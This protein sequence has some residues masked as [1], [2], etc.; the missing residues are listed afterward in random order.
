VGEGNSFQKKGGNNVFLK[1][2]TKQNRREGNRDVLLAIQ[3]ADVGGGRNIRGGKEKETDLTRNWSF[4]SL[5]Q[6]HK[7]R[8]KETVEWNSSEEKS[9][10]FELRRA[11]SFIKGHHEVEEGMQEESD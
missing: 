9:K 1:K 8:G 3:R 7:A 6:G 11:G 2:H 4:V 5:P 10:H